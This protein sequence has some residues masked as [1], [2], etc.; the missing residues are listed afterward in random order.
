MTVKKELIVL[1]ADPTDVEVFNVTAEG[2]DRGRLARS[3][4]THAS[5]TMSSHR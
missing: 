5:T 2:L 4:L 1:A 3:A